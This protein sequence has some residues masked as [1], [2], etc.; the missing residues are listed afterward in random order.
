LRKYAPRPPSREDEEKVAPILLRGGR[1]LF[2]RLRLRGINGLDSPETENPRSELLASR[3]HPPGMGG[4]RGGAENP[5][6]EA[7]LSDSLPQGL[8]KRR[9]YKIP[10]VNV[11]SRQQGQKSPAVR[12]INYPLRREEIVF[13]QRPLRHAR[14]RDGLPCLHDTAG[15]KGS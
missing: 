13:A 1:Q 3:Y 12:R 8:R 10:I 2:S 5:H 7:T 11:S 6:A 4:A 14:P 15:R 9:K